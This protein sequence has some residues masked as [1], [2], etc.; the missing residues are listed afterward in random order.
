MI[1]LIYIYIYIYIHTRSLTHTHSLT[2]TCASTLTTGELPKEC[3]AGNCRGYHTRTLT[4]THACTHT[5]SRTLTQQGRCRRVASQATAG[6]IQKQHKVFTSGP[7]GRSTWENGDLGLWKV[8]IP[9]SQLAAKSRLYN[10]RRAD[11]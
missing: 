1:M 9:K 6:G 2:H 5:L 4:H 11:F 7:M 3:V 10:H 8:N